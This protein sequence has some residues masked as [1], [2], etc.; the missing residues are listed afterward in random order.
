MGGEA[1]SAPEALA[2]W[3]PRSG[4][5]E[6][7]RASV[8]LQKFTRLAQSRHSEISMLY[9]VPHRCFP[10]KTGLFSLL[11]L[12]LNQFQGPKTPCVKTG[13]FCQDDRRLSLL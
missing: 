9:V 3:L 1:V 13:L 4:G 8:C 12:Y 2:A 5:S 10:F 6:G 11:L 7:Q